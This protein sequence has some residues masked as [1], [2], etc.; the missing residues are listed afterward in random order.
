M[1]KREEKAKK[2]L[3][4]ARREARGLSATPAV[5]V[6]AF[7]TRSSAV[8]FSCWSRWIT[9]MVAAD[10]SGLSYSVT[11]YTYRAPG[12]LAAGVAAPSAAYGSKDW[13]ASTH[14]KVGWIKDMTASFTPDTVFLFTDLDV[15]PMRPFDA[16]VRWFVEQRHAEIALMREPGHTRGLFGVRWAFNTGFF[17]L[18]PTVEVRAFIGH[19]LARVKGNKRMLE[20]DIANWLLGAPHPAH[21]KLNWT[22]IPEEL[23]TANLSNVQGSRT[24]AFHSVGVTGNAKFERLWSGFEQAGPVGRVPLERCSASG[25]AHAPGR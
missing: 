21:S 22:L 5:K 13:Y 8:M 6:F 1:K 23:A 25:V 7:T 2:E 16:L 24:V 19:W 3:R 18:R 12:E 10:T 14:A 17:L 20:Q 9:Q 11:S 15:M 4:Q